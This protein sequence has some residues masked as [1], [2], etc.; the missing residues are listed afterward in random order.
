MEFILQTVLLT[1]PI[2]TLNNIRICL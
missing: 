2:K 1:V